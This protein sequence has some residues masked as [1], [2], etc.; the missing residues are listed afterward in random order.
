MYE[1]GQ[2]VDQSYEKAAEYYTAAARQGYVMAQLNL[3][4]L[5]VQG[6]G[7]EQSFETAREL[8]MKA[9][10]QGDENAI[11]ALQE[12]DKD[13]GRTTPSFVPKPLEEC[14]TCYCPHDPSENKL[15]PCNGCHRESFTV[16]K[17]VK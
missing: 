12:L 7:V 14:A 17:N 3:G 16:E 8:W 4:I 9:A 15:R 10:A 2:G 13:E 5:Y 6:Q 1:S 11:G